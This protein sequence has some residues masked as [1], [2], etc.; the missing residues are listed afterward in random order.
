VSEAIRQTNP[1]VR[2][3]QGLNMSEGG[4]EMHGLRYGWLK[5]INVACTLWLARRGV[6]LQQWAPF[7]GQT[8]AASA[9]ARHCRAKKGG[10]A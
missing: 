6:V 5:Q 10:Q 4:T 1:F 3:A 9:R 7:T 2:D 8:G